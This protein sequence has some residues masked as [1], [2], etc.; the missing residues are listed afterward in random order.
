MRRFDCV[1]R[2]F[3]R[4]RLADKKYEF[5]EDDEVEDRN[6]VPLTRLRSASSF[7]PLGLGKINLSALLSGSMKVRYLLTM[8]C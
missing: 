2:I 1:F 7:S 4:K 6:I 5:T 3:R 8:I